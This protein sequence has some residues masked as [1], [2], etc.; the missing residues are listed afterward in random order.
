MRKEDNHNYFVEWCL[1][2]NAANE[3]TEIP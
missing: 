3:I 1:V 2:H